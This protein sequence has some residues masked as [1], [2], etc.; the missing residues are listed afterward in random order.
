MVLANPQKF[1]PVTRTLLTVQFRRAGSI[2]PAIIFSA[3]PLRLNT[4]SRME[5]LQTVP[6]FIR[7]GIIRWIA[8]SVAR[9]TGMAPNDSGNWY[10]TPPSS[11][12]VN[13]FHYG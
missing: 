13:S 9:N 3:D 1:A 8:Q 12:L 7:G 4:K 5:N 2:L 6:P 10:I 11:T